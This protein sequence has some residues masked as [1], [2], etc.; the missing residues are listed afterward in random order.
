MGTIMS[1]IDVNQDT[2]LYYQCKP[3]VM[4]ISAII[5]VNQDTSL[6]YQCKPIV[7]IISAI[8]VN[9]DISL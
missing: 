2:S 4:I 8:D 7:M 5:D 9:G 6:Y 1:V 3:I